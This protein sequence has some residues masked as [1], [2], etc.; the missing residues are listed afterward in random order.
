MPAYWFMYNMYALARNSWKTSDRDKR[1]ERLQLLENNYLAPDTVNEMF[2]ALVTL[3]EMAGRT[4]LKPELSNASPDQFINKG[5]ELI[6]ANDDRIQSLELE[7]HGFENSN[8]K[9]LLLKVP[10]AW[11][12]YRDFILI[13]AIESILEY[14]YHHPDYSFENLSENIKPGIR[15]KYTNVGGQLIRTS[16]IDLLKGQISSY[17][18]IDWEDVHGFYHKQAELYPT[19]KL[20][21]ACLSLFELVHPETCDK[22]FISGLFKK[23]LELKQKYVKAIEESRLRDYSNPFRKM[24]YENMDEMYA[25]LGKP[26]NN[27]FIKMQKSELIRIKERIDTLAIKWQLPS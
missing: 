19:D 10:K 17:E 8:R 26:A 18:V 15:E 25:V 27:S 22:L 20:L 16:Q 23:Y 11:Q 7:G 13:Y 24:V 5:N 12:A 3:E 1:P 2:D 21:H 9:C 14:I 6:K 4:V